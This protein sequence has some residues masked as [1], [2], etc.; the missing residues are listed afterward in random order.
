M[1]SYIDGQKNSLP[2]SVQPS[3]SDQEGPL[4]P[5]F[6]YFY[7]SQ[8]YLLSGGPHVN[9]NILGTVTNAVPEHHVS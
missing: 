2:L 6:T 9:T 7:H 5:V 1:Q 4:S 3:S 8:L